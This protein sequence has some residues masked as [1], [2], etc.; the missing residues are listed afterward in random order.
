MTTRYEKRDNVL[1]CLMMVTFL[2]VCR[3][4]VQAQTTTTT[5]A[6]T[7]AWYNV[8]GT[9]YDSSTLKTLPGASVQLN[10]STGKMV[11][12][13]QTSDNGQYL[14]PGIPLGKYTVK[15]SYMGY[16]TQTFTLTLTGKGGNKKVQDILLK[17]EATLME[18]AVVVGQA[19]EMVVKEDTTVYNASAFSL[20]P[21]SMVE[22]LIKKLPGVVVDDDGKITHNGKEVKQIL[23]D[24]KEFFARDGQ[25]VMKNLP[26]DIVD[27][28]KAYEKKSDLARITG[29][30]DGEEQTVLD[31]EIKKD[32]RRGW[33]GSAEGGYGLPEDRYS[34]R[35]MVNRFKDQQKMSLVG[36][37]G[38]TS[39]N[40]LS[41]NQ[42]VAGSLNLE[43][44]KVELNGG[45]TG[46]FSQSQ[47]AS[48]SNSQNF[49]NRNAAYSNRSSSNQGN[50]KSF[51]TNWRI[52][53]KPDTMTNIMIRPEF[54]LGDSWSQ[55]RSMSATFNDNPYDYTSDP[56]ASFDD[57]ARVI[58]VNRNQNG[59]FN[60]NDN[61]S[62]SLSLQVNRRFNKP[63]RNITLN[64]NGGLNKNGGESSSY[65]QIDY[66][67]ILALTGDDS[68]YHKIQYNDNTTKS[69][70]IS[71][72]LS[73]SEPIG[74]GHYLQFSYQF[75]YRFSD[76]DRDVS[77]IFDPHV[78]QYGYSIEDYRGHQEQATRDTAQCNY[79]TNNNYNHDIRVQY[80]F[81]GT[82]WR[83][84]VGVNLQPQ[85]NEV[86]YT[87]GFKHYE[88][89]RNV[90]NWSPTLNLRYRFSKQE[91][92]QARYSGQSSQPSIT[93]LIPDTL[94]NANPLA[95]SLGNPELL[96]SFT[97]NASIDYN[98]SIT[99]YQRSY[100]ASAQVRWTQNSVANKT[101]YNDVTGGRVTQPVNINGNWNANAHFNFNTAF[102]DQRFRVNN[103]L[104]YSHTNSVGYV[105][106]TVETD[107]G[108]G[109][110]KNVGVTVKNRV[111][112]DNVSDNLRFTF[113][114]DWLE[115]NA[116]GNIYYNRSRATQTSAS[117]LD[118]WGY[119]YGASTVMNFSDIGLSFSTD[120]NM[121]SRRGYA[122][123]A[124]NTNQLIWNAQ[125]SYSFL[126]QRNAILRLRWNDILDQRD[127]ISRNISA[128][129]RTDSDSDRIS[130]YGML[131][132]IYRF[133]AFGTRESRRAMRE[134]VE[135]MGEDG[136]RGSGRGEGE[137][138]GR[139]EG[140]GSRGGFGGP[141]GGGMGGPG[142]GGGRM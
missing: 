43:N 45:L 77:S 115:L 116:H 71:A 6:P 24:G 57:I 95:I 81:T 105:Y 108:Q 101:Q 70:N 28:V 103:G 10:D 134:Q 140:G 25:M 54:S 126:K 133:N 26:A 111:R 74:V 72:R 8:R 121:R 76:R 113:R 32:M 9:V 49:E 35:L 79:V 114:H 14:L 84:N 1:W 87:K 97:H 2:M 138:G 3:F 42:S 37:A 44:D 4:S 34:G 118:T 78:A 38:N 88:V 122:D 94:N 142:G 109:G 51:A 73:Y 12:G 100:N 102:T 99:E 110:T 135:M 80:R 141:G 123:A 30:D 18:E 56:L 15:I 48:W 22:E 55:S 106:H 85:R 33:F 29:I 11:T 104:S 65:S 69:K 68:T 91:Q 53:W 112:G 75:S 23:V 129:S 20:P 128:T 50:N 136:M 120:I 63:G 96:P 21:G 107:D 131:T 64:V 58:K 132:F 17:E 16:K 62:G 67:Q 36:N 124:M 125:I 130:S 41:A 82:K 127:M 86:N 93:D 137:G 98:K 83:F 27:K 60:D 139:G 66:Y 5:Q 7:M 46:R 117:N 47:S 13:R 39:G 89:G 31:L 19:P 52:E 59:S 92:F 90:Y 61:I 119:G 40:G